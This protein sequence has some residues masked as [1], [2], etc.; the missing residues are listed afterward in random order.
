MTGSAADI[1]DDVEADID[2]AGAAIDDGN[3]GALAAGRK[4]LVEAKAS[5]DALRRLL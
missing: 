4:R 3:S 1:I 5:L 2:A